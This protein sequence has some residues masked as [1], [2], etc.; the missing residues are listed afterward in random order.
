MEEQKFFKIQEIVLY[1]IARNQKLCTVR[2]I[3]SLTGNSLD[4]KQ[5]LNA[6][7]NLSRRK[8]IK[9]RKEGKTIIVILNLKQIERVKMVVGKQWESSWEDSW[10]K[11]EEKYAQQN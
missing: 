7:D 1:N 11:I 4:E 5:V 6:I 2:D 3:I 10:K 8:L 9:K